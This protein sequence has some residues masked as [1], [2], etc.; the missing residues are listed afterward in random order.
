MSRLK[1]LRLHGF[2][3][4]ADPTRFV[5]EPGVNAVIGPNGSGKSNMA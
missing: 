5:F 4:F 3:S 2:K 1:E